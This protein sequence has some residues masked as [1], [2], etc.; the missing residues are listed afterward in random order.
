M[1]AYRRIPGKFYTLKTDHRGVHLS[2][3]SEKL[4]T[5]H[6][7]VVKRKYFCLKYQFR[8]IRM[9]SGNTKKS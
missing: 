1:T 6:I 2:L 4:K 5:Q 3:K 8:H 9:H 7:V